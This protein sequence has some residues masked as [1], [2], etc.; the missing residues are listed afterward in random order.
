MVIVF[1]IIWYIGSQAAS[2]TIT[3]AIVYKEAYTV[4]KSKTMY[5][6]TF[7][8]HDNWQRNYNWLL[9]HVYHH[10]KIDLFK[11]EST[12][13]CRIFLLGREKRFLLKYVIKLNTNVVQ[14]FRTPRARLWS[15]GVHMNPTLESYFLNEFF[16][17]EIWV[18][19]KVL[20]KTKTQQ[21]NQK[22]DVRFQNSGQWTI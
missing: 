16:W 9:K 19:G 22:S 20:Q 12:T 15:R 6:P 3:D 11:T 8:Q 10:R 13:T 2:F 1:S 17:V 4:F 18:T 21:Q 7:Y 5:P 14:V